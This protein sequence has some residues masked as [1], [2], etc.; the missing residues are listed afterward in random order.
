MAK[1]V[2]HKLYTDEGDTEMVSFPAHYEVCDRCQGEGVHVNPSIDGH[3]ISREEFDAD[4]D[5]EEAYFS[6]RYDVR[7][8]CCKGERVVLVADDVET[9]SAEQKANW[10][11]LE[12]QWRQEAA[13]RALERM[14]RMM[15]A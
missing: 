4:P 13:D 10:A 6:G 8:E 14:E 2:E 7:C 15:G 11:K 3:G 12:D 5:F 9:F 1:T